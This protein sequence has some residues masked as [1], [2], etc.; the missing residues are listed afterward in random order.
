MVNV[1]AD[2]ISDGRN[3]GICN[4]DFGI[5]DSFLEEVVVELR[6]EA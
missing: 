2:A 3:T 1:K 4:P 5:K 6:S